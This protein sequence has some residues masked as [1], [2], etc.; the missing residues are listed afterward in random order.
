M[1]HIIP[2]TEPFFLPGSSTGC[3]LIHGFT[4]T[5]KE[6]RWMGEYLAKEGYTI[7]GPRLFGHATHPADMIRARWQDWVASVEDGWR[8]LSGAT[9][10]IFVMG[11]SMGGVL[12]LHTAAHFPVAGV[13][14]MATPYALPNDPRLSLAKILARLKPYFPKGPSDWHDKETERDHVSY[15]LYPTR[16]F[17]ELLGLMAE[18][19]ASLPKITA[20]ALII[21]SKGDGGVPP[22][23]ARAIF[24]QLT[25]SDKQ[26]IWVENS[27]HVITKDA[28][29]LRVFRA[30]ADF[31]HRLNKAGA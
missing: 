23:N 19:R 18:M 30:A 27:G 13:V 17:P 7:L 6:M 29:R 8:L 15:P 25:M 2:S 1:T 16:A 9:E 4:G 21:H 28:E 31:V 22:E 20:P 11:L 26:L 3:L 5:P 24:D 14:A 10:R 12:A